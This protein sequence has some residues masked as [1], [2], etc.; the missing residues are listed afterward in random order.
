MAAHPPTFYLILLF[1][2][3]QRE[4]ERGRKNHQNSWKSGEGGGEGGANVLLMWP[5]SITHRLLFAL[6]PSP[7]IYTH[8]ADSISLML[9]GSGI[10][11]LSLSLFSPGGW[12]EG[13]VFFS[14]ILQRTKRATEKKV[15]YI[16]HPELTFLFFFLFRPPPSS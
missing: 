4:R 5:E 13:C 14:S 10:F 12:E 16:A 8:E 7:H 3:G 6:L 11:L 9:G 1:L 15:P 2:P